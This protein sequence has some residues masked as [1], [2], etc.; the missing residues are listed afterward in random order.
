M[1][2]SLRALEVMGVP[3]ADQRRTPRRSVH[4]GGTISAGDTTYLAWIK[5]I[6]ENG[7]CFFTKLHPAVG[8]TVRVTLSGSR[9][10]AYLRRVYEGKVVRVQSGNAGAAVG[11]AIMFT[12]IGT[13]VLRIA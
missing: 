8:D 10:P 7:A 2:E 4:V 5:D 11:V 9:L 3:Y 1:T 13:V 6:S 12:F